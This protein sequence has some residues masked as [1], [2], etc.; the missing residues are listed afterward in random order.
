MV[1]VNGDRLIPTAWA[2][3]GLFQARLFTV[4]SI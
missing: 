2:L 4:R 3:D 1:F